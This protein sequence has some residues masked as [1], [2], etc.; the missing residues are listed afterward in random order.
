MN[1]ALMKIKFAFM[2]INF[3]LTKISFALTR[4]NFTMEEINFAPIE[5]Y[6]FS[7][8]TARQFQPINNSFNVSYRQKSANFYSIRKND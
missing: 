4:F 6:Q 1:F 3:T 7:K 2:K 5:I 8:K